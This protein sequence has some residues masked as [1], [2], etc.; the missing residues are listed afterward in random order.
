VRSMRPPRNGSERW[1][2][3]NS[4]LLIVAWDGACLELLEPWLAA[5]ALPTLARLMRAGATR[6]LRSTIP[7]VTF[8]AWTSFMTAASPARHGITDFTVREDGGY[9]VRFVNASYRRLPTV[10]ALLSAA[11]RRVGVYAMPATYPAEP[12]HGLQV[13]G[14]DTPLGPGF[15]AGFSEPAELAR[16]LTERYGSLAVGGP[17]QARVTNGWHTRAFAQMLDSLRLRTTIVCELLASQD[18]D[19]F[20]VHYGEPDTAAHHFW[21]FHDTCSPRYRADGPADGIF[22]VYRE[23]D[24]ALARLLETVGDDADVLLLSDHGSAGSSDRVIFWNRWLAD[25]GWLDFRRGARVQ[26]LGRALKAGALHW[27]PGALQGRLFRRFEKAAAGTE[28]A[29]RFGGICW[30]KTTAYS[31]EL[32][33]YPAFWFNL[34]G[35]EPEGIVD[36]ADLPHLTRKLTDE[37]MSLRDPFDDGPVVE[38]VYSRAELFRGPF[39]A[40]A[41]DLVA[42]LRRPNGYTYAA[43]S[44][45][46][47]REP[48]CMRLLAEVER[49]GSRGTVMSGCHDPIGMCVASGPRIV[50]GRYGRGELRDAG[51][52]VLALHGLRCAP[53]ADGRPWTDMLVADG[54][55]LCAPEPTRLAANPVP[56]SEDESTEL[57]ERLR[58][59]GYLS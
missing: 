11:G 17:S 40:Q 26:G 41:P 44:S 18:F 29:T 38:A 23:L 56:Y 21:Q 9:R 27:V 3:S 55:P 52:T 34:R 16:T 19:C 49:S 51:A 48:A 25:N 43:A 39:A 24:A 35:R 36:A 57:G 54:A 45:R 1:A 33:Y 14:F 2:I 6:E 12:L 22:S 10:W 31:E 15:G 32:N 42:E 37:L 13:S 59:L 28:S 7:A 20:A 8:P 5:G 58:A 30:G 46:G 53:G 4:M 50:A 47:G